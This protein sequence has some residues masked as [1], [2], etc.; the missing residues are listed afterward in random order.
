MGR[1]ERAGMDLALWRDHHTDHIRHH[2]GE[3][4]KSRFR[5]GA[6]RPI[7]TC[8]SRYVRTERARR[9]GQEG[10]SDLAYLRATCFFF[11]S[12]SLGLNPLP[13]L[14]GTPRSGVGRVQNKDCHLDIHARKVSSF[15]ASSQPSLLLYFLTPSLILTRDQLTS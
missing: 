4:D 6:P 3:E 11:L 1:L 13:V 2:G 7:A 14:S 5:V 12:L 10:A 8:S 9:L 15:S